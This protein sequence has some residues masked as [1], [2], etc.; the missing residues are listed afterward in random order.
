MLYRAFISYSHAD[1]KWARWLMRRLESYRVPANLVGSK[2]RDGPI[3]AKL[4]K[5][6]R[7]RDELPSAGDL[8]STI[9]TALE[10]STA[11]IVICSTASAQSRWVNAEIDAFRQSVR[12][13][14]I[15]SF[16]VDGDPASHDP[17]VACFPESLI[18]PDVEGDPEHEPLAAD[19]RKEGDGRERAFIKLAAGLLGVG[20]DDLRQRESHR[21]LRRMAIVT[22]AALAALAITVMLAISAQVARN[23]AEHRHE[24]AED[25]LGFMVGDLRE[26]LTPIGRLDLLEN[27]GEKAMAYFAKVNASELSEEELTRQA[28]ILTQI[29]EIRVSQH[30]YDTAAKSFIQAHERSAELAESHPGNPAHLFNRGQAEFWVGYVHWRWG[31]LE[32]ARKWLAKYRDSSQ[33]LSNLDP[34]REDWAREVIYGYHNLAV[35][36]LE[37][38]NLGPAESSFRQELK[39]LQE[40]QSGESDDTLQRN[41]S[42]VLSWLGTIAVRKGNLENA[43]N[44]FQKTSAIMESLQ[45]KD[46]GDADRRYGWAYSTLLTAET[47][48]IKGEI[49][50]A[51]ILAEQALK[52]FDELTT[53]DENNKEWLRAS[54]RA[55][56]LKAQLLV[57][58]GDIESARSIASRFANL[59][60]ALITEDASDV[61]IT[62]VQLANAYQLLCLIEQSSG[63]ATRALDT[64]QKALDHMYSVQDTGS[65]NHDRLGRLAQI[66][67]SRGQIESSVGAQKRAQ[68]N[69]FKATSILKEKTGSSR[70]PFLLDPWVRVLL[71]TGHHAEAG[72]VLD[73]LLEQM[74]HPLQPWPEVTE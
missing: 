39:A 7:D 36:A 46:P 8:S 9:S 17:S 47:E 55:W 48:A 72:E 30:Q 60:E 27:V 44:Y 15:F 4:G 33:Q 59:L 49:G 69:W 61:V 57:V 29:G 43:V 51:D 12:E 10:N 56:V 1:E 67:V 28:E 66:L 52:V 37:S 6:F 68:D 62:R 65:L 70:S 58:N 38:D 63:E 11:L 16:I 5:F 23:D 20:L 14:I 18:R 41:I 45:L 19:A 24:Q 74:Y 40:M 13:N 22:S 31:D 73:Q 2:G 3:P 53:L 34:S 50:K 42:D 26:S 71:F 54:A 35:L 32:N 64:N 25:L 21:K